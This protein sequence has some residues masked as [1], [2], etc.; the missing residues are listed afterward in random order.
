MT[1]QE[2][3]NLKIGDFIYTPLSLVNFDSIK[4]QI[5]LYSDDKFIVMEES[6]HSFTISKNDVL[7]CYLDHKKALKHGIEEIEKVLTD[8]KN[9]YEIIYGKKI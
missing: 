8:L 7:S 1:K 2:Y 9:R 3:D 4:Y 5:R 6:G